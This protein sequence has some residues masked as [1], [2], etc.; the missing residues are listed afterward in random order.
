MIVCSEFRR[1]YTQSPWRHGIIFCMRFQKN[2]RF[3]FCL[4]S[5]SAAI[6]AMFCEILMWDCG[7]YVDW[8]HSVQCYKNVGGGSDTCICRGLHVAVHHGHA[9]KRLWS[10]APVLL[11]WRCCCRYAVEDNRPRGAFTRTGKS[12]E[13][14]GRFHLNDHTL[15]FYPQT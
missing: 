14:K 15:G 9:V 6:S 11:S 3:Y 2:R 4:F 12:K 1:R 7:Y 13:T 10:L 5:Q 8:N